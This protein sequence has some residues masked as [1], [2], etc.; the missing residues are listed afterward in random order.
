MI[1]VSTLHYF[2]FVY[3]LTKLHINISRYDISIDRSDIS[4]SKSDINISKSD[5][6]ISVRSNISVKNHVNACL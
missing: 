2:T 3:N 5:V 6:G 1:Q 4:I